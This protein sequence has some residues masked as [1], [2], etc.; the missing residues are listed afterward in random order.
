MNIKQEITQILKTALNK[1]GYEIDGNI[2][3]LSNRPELA[4]YQSN[5]CF[6]L[7]KKYK[8]SPE[9]IA[10][11]IIDSIKSDE[12]C[13]SF[14]A[15]GFINIILTTLKLS[16]IASSLLC[17]ENLGIEKTANPKLILLDYGGANVAKELHMG[18]LRSPIIGQA[19]NNLFVLF[20]NNTISDTHLGDWGL[21]MGL[22]IAQMEED[23]FLDYYFKGTGKKPEITMEMLNVEYPKASLRKKTD[24]EFRQKADNYTLLLQQKKEPFFSVWQEMRNVSVK[25]VERNY[26]NLN[27]HFDIW[28]GESSVSNLITETINIFKNK[29]LARESE[30]AL[31]VDVA[32]EGENIPI[33]KENEFDIQR[34]KNPMPP[35]IIQ[36]YNGGELYMTTDLATILLRNRQFKPDEIVYVTDNR[37]TEHFIKLF[38]C[39]KM[40]EISPENQKLTH[41]AFGTMN[42][43]DGK[44]FKTRSGETIKLE[45]VINMVQEKA[46]EKLTANGMGKNQELA[47]EIGVAALKFGD[48]SNDVGRDYVLD[49]DKFCSFEG[50]TGPYLQYTCAR[51]NSL[52]SKTKED[53]KNFL[54]SS[55]EERNIVINTLKLIDSFSLALENLTLSPICTAVFN[56]AQSFSVFYNNIKILTE[57]DK[58]KRQNY[59]ALCTL[60]KKAITLALN[61]L[62]IDTPEK[63]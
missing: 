23:G 30:G 13:F 38:R 54:I 24:E 9:V 3:S 22:T 31:V 43:K 36:K 18:H 62:A 58:V 46:Q 29:G 49:I 28:D 48:L 44:P 2:V 50:K 1:C 17:S 57:E 21:Q 35:A 39:A 53:G 60:T 27:I 8:E 40:A 52:L 47:R 26:N 55:P 56:L 7:S 11:K 37:Q 63:M 19:I 5:V 14:C 33:P 61:V 20:G 59:I 6:G 51:I 41:V 42:G 25:T 15:P 10:N 12:Y 34:Y 45:D 32:K 4:D 16:S